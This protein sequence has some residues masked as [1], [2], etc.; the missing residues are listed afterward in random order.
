[1]FHHL[2]Q[3]L[4]I[5]ALAIVNARNLSL[6]TLDNGI[7]EFLEG[8]ESTMTDFASLKADPNEEELPV[9]FTICQSLYNHA[10]TG[11]SFLQLYQDN[12]EPWVGYFMKREGNREEFT[13][14]IVLA[15]DGKS[16]LF[17]NSGIPIKPHAWYHACFGLDTVNGHLTIVINGIVL[18]DEVIPYF[19]A[20]SD[21]K[22]KTLR[23]RI[24]LFKLKY[25][26]YWLL[27]RTKISNIQI[28]KAKLPVTE[29]LKIT[30]DCSD[31]ANE[32]NILIHV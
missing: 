1:M 17:W 11:Q 22:P 30:R 6:T 4:M 10:V 20:S 2:L 24:A 31:S 15:F 21:V 18:I 29:M 3:L 26:S 7:G 23:N 13:E 25:S 16:T 9:K 8:P 5:L 32:V 19:V 28:F 12:G 14:A 27:F